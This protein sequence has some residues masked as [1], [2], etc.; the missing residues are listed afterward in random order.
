MPLAVLSVVSLAGGAAMMLTDV[1]LLGVPLSKLL[2]KVIGVLAV[3]LGAW[4]GRAVMSRARSTD[5][6]LELRDGRLYLHVNPGRALVLRMDQVR[7][8]GPVEPVRLAA[9][10]W[11]LGATTFEVQTTLPEGV[12]ASAVV[13][14]SRYVVGDLST[15]RDQLADALR[16][17]P[18]P[19]HA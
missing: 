4:F 17:E 3:L 12:R 10:R 19:G 16:S 11:V 18:D 13:V 1:V 14:G 2:S 9:R 15:A 7:G 5:P 6:A 8:V